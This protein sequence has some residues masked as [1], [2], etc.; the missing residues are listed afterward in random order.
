MYSYMFLFMY[1]QT[2]IYVY[3][4]TCIYV[5]IYIHVCVCIFVYLCIYIYLG[6][7]FDPIVVL[8]FKYIFL[9]RGLFPSILC[10]CSH[11]HSALV[12][13][14]RSSRVVYRFQGI[15]GEIVY[16]AERYE[17]NDVEDRKVKEEAQ[18]RPK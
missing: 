7:Y 16:L 17:K 13:S 18:V 14:R 5:C 12:S 8:Y 9:A 2:Y 11:L 15:A 4:Y 3:I 6:P 10:L 1:I